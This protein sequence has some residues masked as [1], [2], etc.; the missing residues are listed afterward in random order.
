M[1]S[2]SGEPILT[3][4]YDCLRF[5]V[6]FRYLRQLVLWN[7]VQ[8]SDATSPIPGPPPVELPVLE[9]FILLGNGPVCKQLAEVFRI[10]SKCHRSIT[11]CFACDRA[12]VSGDAV[13]AMWAA[14]LF[15]PDDIEFTSC[16]LEADSNMQTLKLSPISREPII[17]LNLLVT[18]SLRFHPPGPIT[19]LIR[20]SA[21]IPPFS[22]LPG[23]ALTGQDDFSFILWHFLASARKDAFSSIS[24]LTLSFGDQTAA[25]HFFVPL[26][27]LMPN[28]GMVAATIPQ[29]YS[30]PSFINIIRR[31]ELLPKVTSLGI[32]LNG[33]TVDV[34]YIPQLLR[35]KG[36]IKQ[37]VFYISPIY[38]AEME[39]DNPDPVQA[40][41][42]DLVK[43]FPKGV[44]IEWLRN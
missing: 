37:V 18:S 40:A 36:A 1:R 10:P 39:H 29:V 6:Q 25:P 44:E 23:F 20:A 32:P 24:L 30:N 26:L 41:I 14:S 27:E 21:L 17:K 7:V 33:D 42:R 4:P 11:V 5:R 35:H 22:W 12:C 2:I 28:V 3:S 16:V 31:Q 15:I 34:T 9:S 43:D 8:S 13:I 19:F 38:L